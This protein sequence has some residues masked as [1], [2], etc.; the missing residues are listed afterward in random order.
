LDAKGDANTEP[1][2]LHLHMHEER[3]VQGDLVCWDPASHR[4]ISRDGFQSLLEF[5]VSQSH[6][7][8]GLEICT[9]HSSQSS[10]CTLVLLS[11]Q[12][13]QVTSLRNKLYA[14]CPVNFG[15]LAFS[16]PSSLQPCGNQS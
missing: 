2:E 4:F 16:R 6:E 10:D 11:H 7:R 13:R 8:F 5:C 1:A 9:N 15:F 12:M 3:D 14:Y